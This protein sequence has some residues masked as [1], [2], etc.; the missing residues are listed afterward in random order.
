ME[1]RKPRPLTVVTDPSSRDSADSVPPQNRV[2]RQRI[3]LWRGLAAA[4]AVAVGLSW[5]LASTG[6]NLS[7]YKHPAGPPSTVEEGFVAGDMDNLGLA[8]P[9]E[10]FEEVIGW[11]LAERHAFHNKPLDY[12]YCGPELSPPSNL[13][14]SRNAFSVERLGGVHAEYIF[15]QGDQT[16]VALVG[17]YELGETAIKEGSW[18]IAEYTDALL[19]ERVTDCYP[20]YA[21]TNQ[22]E[23][24]TIAASLEAFESM[25]KD[26]ARGGRLFPA[27]EVAAESAFYVYR[28]GNLSE[29]ATTLPGDT[30]MLDAPLEGLITANAFWVVDSRFLVALV[31]RGRT[32]EGATLAESFAS[33]HLAELVDLTTQHVR[34][35]GEQAIST[36][37][38]EQTSVPVGPEWD[39]LDGPYGEG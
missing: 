31:L 30:L 10:L 36:P 14:L 15:R 37:V 27:P 28:P 4:L 16:F 20:V 5:V 13:A 8:P 24:P 6:G 9:G 25:D 35:H 3:G 21:S 1:L 39:F 23:P 33:L 29:L 12:T 22:I 18:F 38:D 26:T 34:A 17:A 11:D 2:P 32:V 19:V 7:G